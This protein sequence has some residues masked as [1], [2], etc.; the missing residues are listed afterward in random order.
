MPIT[1]PFFLIFISS[2][3]YPADGKKA[4]GGR[5][6]FIAKSLKMQKMEKY[7]VDKSGENGIIPE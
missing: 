3:L 7:R 2:L 6:K 5:A 1:T 4:S